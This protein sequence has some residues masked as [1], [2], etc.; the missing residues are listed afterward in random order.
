VRYELVKEKEIIAKEII[1]PGK[2]AYRLQI[3]IDE[4]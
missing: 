3:P 1:Y 4:T 2:K